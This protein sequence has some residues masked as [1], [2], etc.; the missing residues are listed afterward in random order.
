MAV[1]EYAAISKRKSLSPTQLAL[2]W[3]KSRWYMGSVII[4]ATNMHQL[5]ENIDA[6]DVELDAAT[7]KEI[8]EVH[9]LHRN[10]NSIN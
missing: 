4:G 10:P 7:L 5:K 3:A 1:A 6:F 2:A 8:D 9:V